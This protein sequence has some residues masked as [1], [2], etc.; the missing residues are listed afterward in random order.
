MIPLVRLAGR[1]PCWIVWATKW[2]RPYSTVD[3]SGTL[4]K[5]ASVPKI[6]PL[7]I[8][9]AEVMQA[10]FKTIEAKVAEG[11]F[12][13]ELSIRFSNLS[14]ILDNYNQYKSDMAAFDELKELISEEGQDHE[15]VEEAVAEIEATIPQVQRSVQVLQ[16]RLL[17]QQKYSDK[18]CILELRPGVGGSEAALF[19][20]DLMQMYINFANTKRWKHHI[21]SRS[22]GNNGFVNEVIISIDD[23][24]AFQA[25]RHESGV[26]RVQRI[27][28]TESKGRIHTST[29]AVV[30]LPKISEGNESSLKEDER[31]FAPGEVRID[32]MR[33]GG[34]GGQHVNTT[35]SAVRLVHIP[36]GITV[37]Q[38]DERSQPRN[39]AKA[40]S[41]LRARL[42]ALERE[43]EIVEQRRMRTDQ[44]T[45]TDRSDKIR[46]YNYP[47]NRVTDHRCGFSLHDL[48]GCMA[49]SKLEELMEKVEEHEFEQRLE[50]LIAQERKA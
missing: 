33:A 19:T 43:K 8:Q 13:Q 35:D 15:L 6:H 14:I 7:L 39:K 5:L 20:E 45:T 44:V 27:P 46:T 41:I 28:L 3:V 24:G 32:T 9:R 11:N 48:T 40:F 47:Q 34:K 17:P 37:M 31:L 21:V 18:P 12:E 36:T 29:A 38:Q 2:T 50:E 10:E 49:G 42:A 30:V 26:H 4:E 16:S 23:P 25:L 22:E 1:S